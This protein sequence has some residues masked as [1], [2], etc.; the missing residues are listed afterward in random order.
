VGFIAHPNPQIRQVAVEN[1]VPYS[2]AEPAVF[3]T[4]SLKPVKNL[5]ILIKDH[6]VGFPLSQM[7]ERQGD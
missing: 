7:R 2:T 6:P 4:E 3:K 1:L 5:T